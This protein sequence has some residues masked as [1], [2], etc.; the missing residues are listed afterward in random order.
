ML[1]LDNENSWGIW[2]LGIAT[3]KKFLSEV[4]QPFKVLWGMILV[5]LMEELLKMGEEL[6]KKRSCT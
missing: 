1:I 4:I 2:R 6:L 5:E 3:T